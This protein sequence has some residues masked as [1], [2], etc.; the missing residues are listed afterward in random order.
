MA[1]N[2]TC[3]NPPL[4][5]E[6]GKAQREAPQINANSEGLNG[7]DDLVF[8]NGDFFHNPKIAIMNEAA[9]RTFE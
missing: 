4:L 3:S 8:A 9:A 1:C 5:V 2:E 6:G 7:Y